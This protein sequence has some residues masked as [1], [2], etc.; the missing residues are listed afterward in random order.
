MIALLK[1]HS[2]YLFTLNTQRILF[3]LSLVSIGVMIVLSGVFSDRYLYLDYETYYFEY[4]IESLSYIKFSSLALSFYF[5]LQLHFFKPYDTL[6]RQLKS[7]LLLVFSKL[8][9]IWFS[10]TLFSI[11]CIILSSIF[12]VL[13]GFKTEINELFSMVLHSSVF[14]IY[15]VLLYTILAYLTKHILSLFIVWFGWFIGEI[16]IEPFKALESLTTFEKIIRTLFISL[17]LNSD[18]TV[19]FGIPLINVLSALLIATVLSFLL[20]TKKSD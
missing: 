19:S 18:N 14:V 1:L 11:Y 7:Y 8:F 4:R 9:I 10:V 5:V 2:Y 20:I 12:S 13:A 15:Y 6:L 17:H 16:I 3:A